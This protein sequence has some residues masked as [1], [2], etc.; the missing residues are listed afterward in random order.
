MWLISDTWLILTADAFHSLI[1]ICFTACSLQFAL[2]SP[3]Q[4]HAYA[5]KLDKSLQFVIQKLFLAICLLIVFIDDVAI[6][7]NIFSILANG[8]HLWL[9]RSQTKFLFCY[10]ISI[11]IKIPDWRES[12]YKTRLKIKYE[13][14]KSNDFFS[15][16]HKVTL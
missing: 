10:T 15:A 6:F 8:I 16:I 1:Q 7:R 4:F 13:S 12:L 11:C 2:A 3:S 14:R 9:W 5:W